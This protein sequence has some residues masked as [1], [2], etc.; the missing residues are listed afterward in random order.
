[1]AGIIEARAE[2][3]NTQIL[4]LESLGAEAETQQGGIDIVGPETYQAN[5]IYAA[6]DRLTDFAEDRTA[7]AAVRL[8]GMIGSMGETINLGG[9]IIKR[10]KRRIGA[11]LSSVALIGGAEAAIPLVASAHEEDDSPAVG[12]VAS[13]A[14]SG[15]SAVVHVSSKVNANDPS[16]EAA[17][18]KY[19]ADPL[20][21]GT[22]WVGDALD[23]DVYTACVGVITRG[24]DPR[25]FLSYAY[26]RST[27][28]FKVKFSSTDNA[29]HCDQV[30][31]YSE[32]VSLE[33]QSK[34]DHTKFKKIGNTVVHTDGLTEVLYFYGMPSKYRWVNASIKNVGKLCVGGNNAHTKI[35]AKISGKF[36]GF[37]TQNFQH[38]GGSSGDDPAPGV[39]S[40]SATFY[41]RPKDIC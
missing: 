21:S 24:N 27:Q 18:A 5:L 29:N 9:D 28:S 23:Y 1:M 11:A 16:Y 20:R 25:D 34:T 30:G 36:T 3:I 4:P 15:T 32:T 17:M 35:R 7:A 19:K 13:S 39:K 22:P 14:P 33:R 37:E 2:A 10:N 40:G 8:Q 6:M 38:P 26:N 31:T 12:H 41:T